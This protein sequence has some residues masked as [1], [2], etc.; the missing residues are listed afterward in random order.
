MHSKSNSKVGKYIIASFIAFALIISSFIN[1]QAAAVLDFDGDGKTDYVV[2]R[3]FSGVLIWYL[4]RSRDGF[5]GT[6]W[7]VY[8]NTVTN[9]KLVPAD[10]DGDGKC[11]IAVWRAGAQA[12]FYILRSSNGTL[13]AISWGTT[14]DNPY[15]TQDFD[16]DGKADP[17]VVRN[18]SGNLVWYIRQ[19][20]N[21]ALR[22]ATFGLSGL[23][24]PVRGNYDG[25]TKADLA[26]YRGG[27]PNP[28]STFY[29]LRSQTNTLLGQQFGNSS[30]D[31]VAPGDYDGDGK[32]DFAVYRDGAWYW[33]QSSNGQVRGVQFGAAT[34][35][36]AIQGDF[37][38][39]G[40]TDPAVRRL[41]GPV[42]ARGDI[43]VLRSMAGFTAIHWGTENDL[44]P[45]SYGN[46]YNP[47]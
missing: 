14:G 11:D 26:V 32:T 21:N 5:Q 9:D 23:D 24:A 47:F 41:G 40:K 43:Y 17:T 29:V 37:D 25:D 18:V 16:G 2:A 27:F 30:T 19:S 36:I 15:M 8:Q 39:D 31:I 13:Q 46:T 42:A 1:A 33:Q 10:Y 35:D 6:Q 20:T 22:A 38:G 45:A 44:S 7:G 12:A 3:P 28:A 34:I 4:Q